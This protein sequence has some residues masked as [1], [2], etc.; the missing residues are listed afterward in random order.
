[1]TKGSIFQLMYRRLVPR[2]CHAK[3]IWAIVHRLCRLIWNILPEGG[4]YQE[5]GAEVSRERAQRRAA[6]MIRDRRSLGYRV[7]PI[8]SL[9]ATWLTMGDINSRLTVQSL[10]TGE[11]RILE[12]AAGFARYVPTG[13]LIY[14]RSEALVAVPFDLE[15]LDVTGQEVPLGSDDIAAV[16]DRPLSILDFSHEGTLVYLPQGTGISELVWVDRQ[17]DIEPL[18]LGSASEYRSPRLSPDGRHLAVRRASE[19]QRDIW[20]YDLGGGEQ[21][22]RLTHGGDN[23]FQIWTP[24][25]KS[26]VFDMLLP[27]ETKIM[28]TSAD[29]TML[30]PELLQSVEMMSVLGRTLLGSISPDGKELFYSLRLDIWVL[31]LEEGGTPRT[32]LDSQ[33]Q[34]VQPMI[35][36]DGN[37]IAYVSDRSGR[38]EVWVR[39]YP[40]PESARPIQ[41]SDNGGIEPVWSADGRELFY[42]EGD[43]LKAVSVERSPAL[44]FGKPQVVFRGP[45][46]S[47]GVPWATYDVA[48]DDRFIIRM[49]P[50]D[51]STHLVVVENWFDELKR[52]VP[53]N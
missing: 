39:S 6:K 36:R 47:E 45:I 24:D 2:L 12:K 42:L 33:F 1:M 13:H 44:R 29:G 9:Q 53:T 11:R 34:E 43:T 3:A 8:S 25:G 10:E 16:G 40:D 31:S 7:E 18:N 49:D 50:T 22:V 46:R 17:G 15:R 38:Y 51:A 41:V 30:E 21:P 4:H 37:L 19:E 27:A 32:W 48:P 14:R 20:V 23:R 5:H 26:V 28:R 35:S 52:L